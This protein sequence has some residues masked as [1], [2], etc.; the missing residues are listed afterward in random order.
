MLPDM[1]EDKSRVQDIIKS[2]EIYIQ[3]NP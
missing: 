1:A 2:K 3:F